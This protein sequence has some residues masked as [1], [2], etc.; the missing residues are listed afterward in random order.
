MSQRAAYALSM[1]GSVTMMEKLGSLLEPDV[2]TEPMRIAAATAL[3]AMNLDEARTRLAKYRHDPSEGVRLKVVESVDAKSPGPQGLATL[4]AMADDRSASVRGDVA[5]KLGQINEPGS[6]QALRKQSVDGVASVRSVAIDGL[7]SLGQGT[8][9]PAENTEE[10]MLVYSG[11]RG[12]GRALRVDVFW[13]RGSGEEARLARARSRA[14]ELTVLARSGKFAPDVI[15][16]VRVRPL[17]E[18][19]N[20]DRGYRIA[21]NQIRFEPGDAWER[22]WVDRFLAMWGSEF[23][24]HPVVNRTQDYMSLF[25]CGGGC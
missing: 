9:M 12:E 16:S 6:L 18:A 17:S 5:G 19:I 24:A 14:D 7:R 20:K 23:V 10:S 21:G 11:G 22:A 25:F 13:C 8:R 1:N 15:A 3:V 4:L 2:N